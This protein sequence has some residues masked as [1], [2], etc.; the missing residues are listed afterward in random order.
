[1]DASVA[2]TINALEVTPADHHDELATPAELANAAAPPPSNVGPSHED[3]SFNRHE[4]WPFGLPAWGELMRNVQSIVIH[5]T[6]GWPSADSANHFSAQYRCVGRDFPYDT[7]NRSQNRWVNHHWGIGPQYFVDSSGTVH[8]LIGPEN[9]DGPPR[10]T[11]HGELQ[12]I[13]SLGI[14]QADFADLDGLNPDTDVRCRRLDPTKAAT[15]SDLT[16]MRLYGVLHPNGGEHAD[17]SLIWFAMFPGFTGSGDLTADGHALAA[18]WSNW[19][20]S[21]FTER[22]YRSLAL[23]CRLALE[24]NG[25]PRNFPLLPYAN[26]ER[27]RNAAIF[28]KLLLAD[29]ARD[30]IATHLGLTLADVQANNATY[31][32]AYHNQEASL[33]NRFFGSGAHGALSTPCFKGMISHFIN[34][35]HPCPGPLFDWHRFAREVWDWWWYP[36]DVSSQ[37]NSDT[38]LLV[39]QPATTRRAYQH[40]HADTPLIEYFFDAGGTPTDYDTLL[41]AGMPN[42]FAVG[43]NVPVHALAN[44]V[45]VAARFPAPVDG[46]GDVAPPGF[47]LMRHEVFHENP[48]VPMP[49]AADGLEMIVPGPIDYDRAPTY[50]W[51]LITF[52]SP[53][54]VAVEQVSNNNP[55]WLN[56]FAM[57]L[58]ECELAVAYHVAHPNVTTGVP[59]A[60]QTLRRTLNTA[61]NHQP[62]GTGRPTTGTGIEN[63]AREYRRVANALS[64][65]QATLFPLES[66]TFTPVRVILGDYLGMPELLSLT[67]PGFQIEV[68]SRNPLDVPGADEGTVSASSEAWWRDASA[69]ARTETNAAANLPQNGQVHRYPTT[70]FLAWING[71]TWTSEWLKYGITDPANPANPLPM[72]RPNPRINL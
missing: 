11:W 3:H 22:D 55:D 67:Q 18:G 57:R 44:G 60:E 61:W 40:A 21:L 42:R 10:R 68:F 53:L 31:Q 43:R 34:G 26:V 36:F 47:L 45:I 39:F 5:G 17:L 35:H 62:P 64:A 6:E 7:F 23:L 33:W 16:G 54:D 51:S 48:T 50:V 72:P 4:R 27:L 9:L 41:P 65:G 71:I 56:R 24:Q 59:A 25:I 29:A 1:M 38:H 30:Q 37:F 63:D 8:V 69:A 19:K 46:P 2:Q 12:N 20:N 52:V 28:R 14:E 13:A 70:A 32:T 58:K 66:G 15:A 49:G